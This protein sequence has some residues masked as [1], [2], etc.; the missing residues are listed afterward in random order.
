[1]RHRDRVRHIFLRLVG[2]ISEHH[3]LISGSDRFDIVLGH[4]IFFCLQRFI[5]SERNIRRLLVNGSHDAA[6][7]RIKSVFS[8]CVTDLAHRIAHDLLNIHICLCRDLSHDHDD[9]CRHTRL[10][11][12]TAHRILLHQCVQ[13]R[14]GNLIAHLIRMSLSYRL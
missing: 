2:S 7:V 8:S 9:S 10:A 12:N 5:D 4:F 3:S 11:C 6:G 13:D 1:M 14:I